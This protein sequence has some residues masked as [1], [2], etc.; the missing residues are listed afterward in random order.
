[1]NANAEMEI[2]SEAVIA[3]TEISEAVTAVDANAEMEIISEAV[4]ALTE[5]SEAVTALNANAEMDSEISEA[6]TNNVAASIPNDLSF[7]YAKIR[8]TANQCYIICLIHLFTTIRT[9]FDSE[10]SSILKELMG[11]VDRAAQTGELFIIPD[12]YFPLFH[13]YHN[14]ED[15]MEIFDQPSISATTFSKALQ[16]E[17]VQFRSSLN[18]IFHLE[19]EMFD[20]SQKRNVWKTTDISFLDSKFTPEMKAEFERMHH[21][22]EFNIG[23]PCR[24]DDRWKFEKQSFR[25]IHL[26]E[27][28]ARAPSKRRSTQAGGVVNVVEYP[29]FHEL[30]KFEDELI[31]L[32]FWRQQNA[33]GY[34]T[35]ATAGVM[36]RTMVP[37]DSL[38]PIVVIVNV[39][40]NNKMY[41][42]KMTTEKA[43]LPEDFWL[44]V[45]TNFNFVGQTY[46]LCSLIIHHGPKSNEGHYTSYHLPPTDRDIA[47]ERRWIYIDDELMEPLEAGDIPPQCKGKEEF[48]DINK[49]GKNADVPCAIVFRI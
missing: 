7:G 29:D 19:E 8:N 10:M 15:V 12:Q 11:L 9:H 32:T 26:P 25:C 16:F 36:C 38:V 20:S 49:L 24:N 40:R 17:T 46:E 1:M 3:L 5:I 37:I 42:N 22:E 47:G 39:K 4:I 28:P 34:H 43:D 21:A 14:H 31:N 44:K 30:V 35:L 13:Y 33:E 2:N 18:G 6:A 27:A 41:K 48:V 23:L 45:P